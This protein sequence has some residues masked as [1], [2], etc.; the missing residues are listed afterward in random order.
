MP[1]LHTQFCHKCG[2]PMLY[3]YQSVQDEEL[4]HKECLPE[5]TDD[6]VFQFGQDGELMDLPLILGTTR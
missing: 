2:K 6:W 4:Y 3:P 5:N 1:N